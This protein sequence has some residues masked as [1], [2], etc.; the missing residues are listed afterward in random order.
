MLYLRK[1]I[2]ILAELKVV[3][4]TAIALFFFNS[5]AFADFVDSK[6]ELAIYGASKIYEERH[7]VDNGFFMSQEGWMAGVSLNTEN[8][9]ASDFYTSFQTKLGY[10]QVDYTSNGTGTMTGISDYQFEISGAFGLGLEGTSIRTTPYIGGGFRYLLNAS[11]L[12]QSSTG[13][14]GYDRVSRYVYIPIGINIETGY[15]FGLL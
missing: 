4:F 2:G 10:G 8:Y 1:Y 5:S 14:Y 12:Q 9:D 15:N 11:G 7:P 13:H 3:M 6:N